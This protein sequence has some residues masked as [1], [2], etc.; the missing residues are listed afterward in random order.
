MT[1]DVEE[2]VELAVVAA[3]HQDRHAAE[4]VGAE[5]AGIGQLTA[6]AEEQRVAAKEHVLLALRLFGA[7]VGGD[8]LR[9]TDCANSVVSRSTKSITRR[10][11]VTWVACCTWFP[12]VRPERA[13]G[14]VGHSRRWA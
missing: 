7:G 13:F 9:K 10:V 12:P 8:G 4:I 14:L 5:V 3:H 11:S 2:G 6:Q 1:A